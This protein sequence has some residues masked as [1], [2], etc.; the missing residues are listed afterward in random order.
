M[1]ERNGGA[2]TAKWSL[3][4]I[5]R[6]CAKDLDRCLSSIAAYPDEI[7]IVN[8]GIDENEEGFA[9][10]NKIAKSFGAKVL[11]FP[12]VQDFAKARQFSFDNCSNDVVMWLDSDDV[13]ENPRVLN[14]VIRQN[15]GNQD[16]ECLYVEYLYDFDEKGVC[17]TVLNRERVV[18]RRCFEWRAPIHETLCEI[19]LVR[20]KKVPP[21]AGRIKHCHTRDDEGQRKSL[22]R[23][24]S[25]LE[26]HFNPVDK[27]G[28]G[29]YCE[30]RM[31]FYWANTL[32]GLDKYEEALP[33]YLEYIPRS[34]S[35]GEIM[36]AFCSASECA[37]IMKRFKDARLLA[38]EAVNKNP[39][40]PSPYWFL[41]RAYGEANNWPLA[42]HWALACLERAN[43]FQQEMVTNPKM[44]FG[45]SALLAA[46]AKYHQKKLDGIDKLL[47][48]AERYVGKEDHIVKELRTNIAEAMQKAALMTA[49]KT[50]KGFVEKESGQVGV[51][52][53]AKLA[54]EQI[55]SFPEVAAYLPKERPAGK[56]SIAFLCNGGMPGKWGPELLKTGIG[57]SEEAV[58][59]LSEQFVRFGWHVEV[60]APCHEQVW[61]GVHW[62]PIE[63]YSGPE[64]SETLDV[65]VIWRSPHMLM[66]GGSKARRTYTWLHDM[67]SPN[68]WVPGI[69]NGYDG[70]FVLSQFHSD[71][72][73]FVSPKKK[74][75]SANGLPTDRLVPIEELKNENHRFVFA[76][77]PMRD[78]ETVLLWW[79]KI[80]EKFKDAELDIYYGFHPTLVTQAQGTD[81]YSRNIAE[82]IKRITVLKNQPGVNWHGFVGHDELHAGFAKAG[83]WLYP[84]M[85]PEISCITGMK[86]QAHGVVP[87]TVNRAAMV[88]TVKHGV[89]I[90]NFN[91][92]V[93]DQTRW[94]EALVKAVESPPTKEQR[95]EMAKAA[96]ADFSWAGVASQWISQFEADLAKPKRDRVYDR[97]RMDL[98]RASE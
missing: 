18:D 1:S 51:R 55:K 82:T 35:T 11:H 58:V 40:A 46:T 9:E 83:F 15:F 56:R 49:Y 37:R 14:Q 2:P 76:S 86:M 66:Y 73:D 4:M 67:P 78:L 77:C 6:N 90:E 26:H 23:N 50:L 43:E 10:T 61:N 59:Y 42:E 16:T 13:V 84:T 89:K 41:A 64:D 39:D 81:P 32:M 88:E 25:V 60:Y 53:L 72:Y 28:L 80:K 36:Q 45:G 44:V 57:G 30:E 22:Q 95:I 47:D 62:Y 5:V 69:E 17:T 97:N 34:G 63:R 74:I 71:Q 48:I 94:F 21:Q 79:E 27:G 96:R 20:G 24:L 52:N 3:A 85:F 54:P 7:V 98:I 31:L 91:G 12:W 70:I 29:E 19:R 33:K 75:L 68:M 93:E 8:T 92:T 87:I 38:M 65:L